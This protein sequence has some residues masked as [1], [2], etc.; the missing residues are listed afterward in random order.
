MIRVPAADLAARSQSGS[1][2][3][4]STDHACLAIPETA[5]VDHGERQLVFV[6]SMPGTFDAVVVRLGP[7]CGDFY[8]VLGGLEPEQRVAVAGAFLIDAETRLNPSLA[9]AY[10]GANQASAERR[11]PEVRV[12]KTD[13]AA[14]GPALPPDELALVEKQKVCPV[15]DL[16]LNA[17]GGPVV[18]VVEGRKV[19]LCCKGC[20]PR[21]QANPAKY[22]AKLPAP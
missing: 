10:F 2:G 15:T 22:L 8:P 16:P 4:Q 5:V 3:D 9:I 11:T 7:R 17:M 20:E 14:K 19:F 12:A 1:A 13:G 18:T 21:L 6:E